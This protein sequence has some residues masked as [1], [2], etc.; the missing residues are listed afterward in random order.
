MRTGE[1][2]YWNVERAKSEEASKEKGDTTKL[3]SKKKTGALVA[4]KKT[5]V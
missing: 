2:T 5:A 1:E 4:G 3:K